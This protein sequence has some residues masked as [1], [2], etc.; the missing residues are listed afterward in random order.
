MAKI[1]CQA[2]GTVH[3]NSKINAKATVVQLY[4]DGNK[5]IFIEMMMGS[6]LY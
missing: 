2:E 5:W 4:H 3:H 6:T 1:K